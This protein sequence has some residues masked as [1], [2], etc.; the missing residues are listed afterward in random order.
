MMTEF[1]L[2]KRCLSACQATVDIVCS[3]Q[4]PC[5]RNML[6]VQQ[7][8]PYLAVHTRQITLGHAH[9]WMS[10]A[11]L[12]RLCTVCCTAMHPFYLGWQGVSSVH[13]YY[14]ECCTSALTMDGVVSHTFL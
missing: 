7:K 5:V 10:C 3:G 4:V 12:P 8:L 13:L 9:A 1:V 11:S 6:H 14:D 2:L